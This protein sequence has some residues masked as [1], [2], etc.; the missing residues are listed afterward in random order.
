MTVKELIEHFSGEVMVGVKLAGTFA[1]IHENNDEWNEVNEHD[2]TLWHDF[3]WSVPYVYDNAEIVSWFYAK[4]EG[5][6]DEL[7]IWIKDGYMQEV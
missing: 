1:K 2:L 5:E 3:N 7:I 6:C 4:Y